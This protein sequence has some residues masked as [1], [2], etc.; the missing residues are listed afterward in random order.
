MKI[1]IYWTIKH[2][3]YNYFVNYSLSSYPLFHFR[4]F[5]IHKMK[6]SVK[7]KQK[8]INIDFARQLFK[9]RIMESRY[10]NNR[11]IY[12][13]LYWSLNQ[14]FREYYFENSIKNWSYRNQ[15]KITLLENIVRKLYN[16]VQDALYNVNW[17]EVLLTVWHTIS[18]GKFILILFT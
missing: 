14:S 5:A 6:K 17:L 7:Y 12:L 4:R 9:E 2:N 8:Y 1:W 11:G 13:S 18:K 15:S 10:L 3:K 16:T